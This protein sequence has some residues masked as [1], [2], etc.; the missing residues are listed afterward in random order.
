MK[1]QLIQKYYFLKMA[2]INSKEGLDISLVAIDLMRID[3]ILF[4]R[5]GYDISITRK[6]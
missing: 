5:Y 1:N 4:E 6:N 2:R 3:A